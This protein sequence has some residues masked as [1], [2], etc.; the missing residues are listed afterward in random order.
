MIV[1]IKNR[2]PAIFQN[3]GVSLN[4]PREV[5]KNH[6]NT[7]MYL[8]HIA[9]ENNALRLNHLI[10]VF[11]VEYEREKSKQ[12]FQMFRTNFLTQLV[13]L[14]EDD[15]IA[16]IIFES[17]KSNNDAIITKAFVKTL[18]EKYIPTHAAKN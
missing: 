15:A 12:M 14:N 10:K 11:Q 6:I 7:C 13:N 4:H 5:S 1:A 8:F 9:Q 17:F 18:M 2:I 16:R 3:A